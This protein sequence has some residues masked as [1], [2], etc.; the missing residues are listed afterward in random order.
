LRTRGI[1]P[2]PLGAGVRGRGL[3]LGIALTIGIAPPAHAAVDFTLPG[4]YR[5]L[6]LQAPGQPDRVAKGAYVPLVWFGRAGKILNFRM[7]GGGS[8]LA[9][10]AGGS[11]TYAQALAMLSVGL[12]IGPIK[13]YLG[14][15]AHGAYP[16]AQP[17]GVTGYPY[18]VMPEVGAEVNLG[19][20]KLDLHA[21][22]G[23]V[24][25]LSMPGGGA[26]GATLT[27][28]GGRVSFGF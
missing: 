1:F 20:A 21:A 18:G 24:W 27:D 16:L 14:G 12:P 26:Y 15:M 2:H 10:Q 3:C 17:P 19:L 13:P 11:Y 9:D 7:E 6:T 5:S 25:G 4:S 22:Q 28:V 23:P 8:Y